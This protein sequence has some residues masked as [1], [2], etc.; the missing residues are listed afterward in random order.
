MLT[1]LTDLTDRLLT[2]LI[3]LTDRLLTDVTDLTDRLLTDL[4]KIIHRLHSDKSHKS[5]LTNRIN[6][7]N[8]LPNRY[9]PRNIISK[10]SDLTNLSKH[11]VEHIFTTIYNNQEI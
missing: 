8:C 3:D 10:N 4:T 5:R 1:D 11:Q 9:P 2:D 7:L 6:R